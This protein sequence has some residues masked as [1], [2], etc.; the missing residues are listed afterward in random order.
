MTKPLQYRIYAIYEGEEILYIG[1]SQRSAKQWYYG[2]RSSHYDREI[3]SYLKSNPDKKFIIK[4][5]ASYKF[6][7]AQSRNLPLLIQEHV[8]KFNT[9]PNFI[10][11]EDVHSS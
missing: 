2:I 6:K 9:I 1:K 3:K 10:V 4:T 11:E 7:T 8:P 5:L